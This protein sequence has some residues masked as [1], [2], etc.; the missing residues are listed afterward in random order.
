MVGIMRHK[1]EGYFD[2]FEYLKGILVFFLLNDLIIWIIT[3][4]HTHPN[5]Y[6]PPISQQTPLWESF[7]Y[8]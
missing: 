5:G 2:N 1:L 6:E 7:R 4:P 8:H 3:H